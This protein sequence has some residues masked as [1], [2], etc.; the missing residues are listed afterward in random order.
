MVFESRR[1]I[2]KVSKVPSGRR[3]ISYSGNRGKRKTSYVDLAKIAMLVFVLIAIMGLG[4]GLYGISILHALPNVDKI[5]SVIPSETTKIYS[6]DNVLLADLHK[7]ENRSVVH[8][9]EIAPDARNALVAME[10]S[11]FFSHHGIDLRGIFRALSKDIVKGRAVEGAS[12]LT[13]QLARNIF[14]TREKTISRKIGEVILAMQIERKYTKEEIMEMYLNQVYWGHN[15]YGIQAAGQVYFGK[16]AK[17]LTLPEAAMLIGLLKGPELYSPYKNFKMAKDRQHSVL[18]RMLSLGYID[19]QDYDRALQQPVVLVGLKKTKYQ[20]PYFTNYVLDQLVKMYGETDVYSSGMKVYTTLDYKLQQYA[21]R[22]ISA[23]L[24][25]ASQN[26]MEAALL[27][28][29]PRTGYILAMVGGKDFIASEY[30]RTTQSRRQPGSAFKPFAYLTALEK[31]LSPGTIMDDAPVTYNS[32]DGPY[33]PQNYEKQYSGSMP[34]RRALELSK[35]VIA[36]KISDLI[37]AGSIISTARSLGITTPLQEILS[38]PLGACEVS[39]MELVYA[40]GV[41]ANR[42]I[43]TKPIS[44]FRIEDRNGVEIYKNNIHTDTVYDENVINILVDMMKGVVLNGT[45]RGAALPRPMAGKTGTT[46]DYRDAW[47]V[48]FVP[49]MVTSTW[50]GNDNN[51][52]MNGVAGGGLPAKIWRDYMKYALQSV[53]VMDFPKPQGMVEVKI[54]WDSGARATEYCP[55][56]RTSLEKFW[57][58]KVPSG[59]CNIHLENKSKT[60]KPR[61]NWINEF[62]GESDDHQPKESND[63]TGDADQLN[64]E[65]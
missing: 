29:N 13:Q 16:N 21:E 22:A 48:G 49:Q 55:S 3:N 31:G 36:V 40:Y 62:F 46:S 2:G 60:S 51:A 8:L 39:M 1:G 24:S 12:T 10:D 64:S 27:S 54:C 45:G 57:A 56:D 65:Y 28:I 38:L 26:Q 11:R 43:I 19:Q 20:A 17:D 53:P 14:L 47:F 15:T 7:E 33:S 61:T 58:N 42:G 59:Y 4:G 37:G 25:T 35:N 9:S 34:L 41:L 52:P 5:T 23:S 30:N 6:A 32:F 50:L 18:K 44:I 63:V